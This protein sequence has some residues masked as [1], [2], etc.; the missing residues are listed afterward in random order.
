M[1]VFD[2]MDEALV[3]TMDPANVYPMEYNALV[4]P[5]FPRVIELLHATETI[6]FG[7]LL[8]L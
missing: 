8:N 6:P 3:G 5:G 4:N 1:I 7:Y 2:I